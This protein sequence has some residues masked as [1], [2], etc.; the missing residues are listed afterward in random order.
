MAKE[1]K[2]W[3]DEFVENGA[4]PKN[5][6]NWPDEASGA[7]ELQDKIIIPS[8]TTQRVVCDD[9]FDGLGTVTVDA[10]TRTIDSNIKAENIKKDVNILGVN[11]TYEGSS[12]TYNITK[13]NAYFPE[14][15][16]DMGVAQIGSNVYLFG[17]VGSNGSVNDI[18]KFDTDTETIS[19]LSVT[20]PRLLYGMGVATFGSNV[21]LFGGFSAKAVNTIY[22]FNTETETISALSTILPKVFFNMGVA[23]MG[24]NVYLFGGLEKSTSK[25]YDIYK[26]SVDF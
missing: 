12:T 18:Y 14:K 20:L 10:V 8:I 26:F 9:N 11:G 24:S 16:A 17:G 7:I 3:I 4:N 21:Y 19:A 23:Q 2:D 15:L 1:F 13:L 22:K 25:L 5:V 6:P